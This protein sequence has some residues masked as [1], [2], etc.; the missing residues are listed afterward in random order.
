MQGQI[1]HQKTYIAGIM[2]FY[3]YFEFSDAFIKSSLCK[4]RFEPHYM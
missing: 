1:E 3:E 2:K 4:V